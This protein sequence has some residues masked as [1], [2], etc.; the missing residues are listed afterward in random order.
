VSQLALDTAAQLHPLPVLTLTVPLEDLAFTVLLV[1]ERVNVQLEVVPVWDTA[2][3]LPAT[4]TVADLALE[5]VFAV[6]EIITVPVALPL[7][8][9]TE[10]H[11]ALVD[12]DHEQ[13]VVVPTVTG[14]EPPDGGNA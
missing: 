14:A 4:L 10:T 5:L 7:P 12:V 2:T 9:A 13:P 11:G 8:L 6:A 1:G 3:C